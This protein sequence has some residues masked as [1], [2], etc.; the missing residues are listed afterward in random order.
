MV[1]SGEKWTS[2]KPGKDLEIVD[3][4][5]SPRLVGMLSKSGLKGIRAE[6]CKCSHT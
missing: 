4:N 1:G 6:E 5:E 2:K 3:L